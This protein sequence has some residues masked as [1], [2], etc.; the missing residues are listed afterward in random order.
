[1]NR[2][3]IGIAAGLL[4]LAPLVTQTAAT[5]S[6][7]SDW[8]TVATF[9]ADGSLICSLRFS[10]PKGSQTLSLENRDTKKMKRESPY[11]TLAGL[12][13]MLAGKK[14]AIRYI[15]VT[16]GTTSIPG[17]KADWSH[18]SSDANSRIGF[19]LETDFGRLL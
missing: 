16:V 15:T 11:F 17:V 14:G 3:T 9:K 5:P 12:P 19:F 4:M 6:V 2:E 10:V 1:M 18:G 7:L 13:P 8:S